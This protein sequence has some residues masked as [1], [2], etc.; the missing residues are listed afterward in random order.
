MYINKFRDLCRKK[1]RECQHP[2]I[3][4][5]RKRVL[6]LLVDYIN[7]EDR[8]AWP[9]FDTMAEDLGCDR[10][11]VIRAI[12]TARKVGIL[13]RVYKGGKTKRGGTSNRYRFNL[14]LVSRVPLGEAPN[15]VSDVSQPS[16]SRATDLVSGESPNLLSDNLID[17]LILEREVVCLEEKNERKESGERGPAG[18]KSEPRTSKLKPSPTKLGEPRFSW[19]S[20]RAE[21]AH[22]RLAA[23]WQAFYRNPVVQTALIG[24]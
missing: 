23:E 5:A 19:D 17:N 13:E 18:P 7:S 14:D 11:T 4:F 9:S 2:E 24:L 12:N 22:R 21:M 16:V 1:I 6:D 10:R 20:Y 8:T 15:L 3:T